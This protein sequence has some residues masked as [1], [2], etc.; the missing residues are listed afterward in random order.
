MDGAPGRERRLARL[1]LLDQAAEQF[2][3]HRVRQ[4]A[5]AAARE[6]PR[7]RQPAAGHGTPTQ[8]VG[9]CENELYNYTKNNVGFDVWW[10][11]A[12]GNRL[13]FGWDYYDLD[14]TRVDYDKAHW[15]KLW[16]EYKNT[17][18][19]TLTGRI[20]YQYVKR[21]STPTSATTGSERGANDP[22]FLLPYTSAFD[23]QSSTTNL[24]KLYLDW[25]PMATWASRS[26]AT[27]PRTTT[28][29]SRYGR[30]SNDRQGYFLSG[31]WTAIRTS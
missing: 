5:D 28:T 23:L 1:L 22:N 27:G 3:R 2:G 21:D 30:T 17:M 11:F 25:T 10:K 8:T 9:N 7:L 18:L 29:M 15:N 14:Q 20:K 31:N 6:R 19:D 13:G 26:K 12:R 4:R 16:V 24:V